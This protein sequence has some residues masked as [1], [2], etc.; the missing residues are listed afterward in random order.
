MFMDDLTFADELALPTMNLP[1][2]VLRLAQGIAYPTLNVPHYME[3]LDQL[4]A[5]AQA[6]IPA[7]GS[8]F[9]RAK[10]V[11]DFL[12]LQNEFRGNVSDYLDPRNSYFNDV[13]DRGLG[14]PITLSVLYLAIAERLG[15]PAFGVNL[16]GHFIV[17][18]RDGEEE[19]FLDPFHGGPTISRAECA[20]LVEQ[21]TGYDGLF[22]EAW[23]APVPPAGILIRILN[24]LRIVC[25][26]QETWPEAL[27]VMEHLRLM[28]PDS[29]DH[30]R[31][32][33]LIHYQNGSL[34]PAVQY[35]EAYLEKEP[36][37]PEAT[38]IREHFQMALNEWV[39]M[40]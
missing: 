24:N 25:V 6:H 27:A 31:D 17:G 16:P 3:R 12:F 18:L 32:L 36:D 38:A 13:L 28:Q 15:V 4:A 29:A 34:R 10:D 1:R 11:A 9:S 19:L 26:Q 22:Q 23:L 20:R 21:S 8:L 37:S 2:A 35:L 40:N 30:L 39:R 7:T 14:I 33:G 5:V